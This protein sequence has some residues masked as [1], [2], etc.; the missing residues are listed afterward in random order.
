MKILLLSI[1]FLV[2]A[3]AFT[4]PR[5]SKQPAS[6][7][8]IF[9]DGNDGS[10]KPTLVVGATGR[11]GRKVV[12]QL[13][14]QNKTVRALVRSQN[15]ARELF[16]ETTDVELVVADL[17]K[18]QDYTSVLDKAVEGCESI[19]SVSGT[20][21]FSMLTDFLPWRLANE[22]VSSWA[23]SS[24]PYYSN[25]KAQCLLVDLA[26]KYKVQRFVRLTGLTTGYSP[27]NLVT[28]IFSSLLSLTT[29]YHFFCENYLRQSQVPYVI[30]RPGGLADEDRVSWSHKL[31]LVGEIVVCLTV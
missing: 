1:L 30:V 3:D 18:Y 17:G 31:V 5:N 28:L 19:I 22:D 27:F 24:H 25:Y 21:R 23:D 4:E 29:R 13:L 10:A 7:T 6:L 16:G 8:R 2:Q 26:Q 20:L 15:K 12:E 9:A 11:V 14:E